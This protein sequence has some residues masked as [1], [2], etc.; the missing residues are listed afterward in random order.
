MIK[1][2]VLYPI[3]K[4]NKQKLGLWAAECAGHVLPLFEKQYPKDKRPRNAIKALRKWVQDGI[5]KMAI[6]R[7]ASL[8]A[9][10]AAR[11]AKPDSA[12]RFAARAAGQA[13]ASAHV[14]AHALA[15]VNYAIKAAN[16]AGRTGEREW[17]EKKLPRQLKAYIN[18]LHVAWLD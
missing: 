3:T 11:K 5:F 18:K 13:V 14:A 16:A 7:K 10:A 4:P 2:S 9:H 6:I 17:Q 8:S 12:A 15:A 1:Y